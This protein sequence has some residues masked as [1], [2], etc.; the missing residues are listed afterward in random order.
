MPNNHHTLII[1]LLHTQ[2]RINNKLSCLPTPNLQASNKFLDSPRTA[3]LLVTLESIKIKSCNT[4]LLKRIS[5]SLISRIC[6]ETKTT[7][8][9]QR[10][11]EK[12]MKEGWGGG[13]GKGLGREVRDIEES[14]R[15]RVSE[16]LRWIIFFIYYINMYIRDGTGMGQPCPVSRPVPKPFLSSSDLSSEYFRDANFPSRKASGRYGTAGMGRDG[17]FLHSPRF[18]R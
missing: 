5:E 14:E 1:P 15:Q 8:W 2:Q 13:G 18:C 10:K 12:E 11:R 7:S 3:S 9:L 4:P 17:K 16:R 6:E